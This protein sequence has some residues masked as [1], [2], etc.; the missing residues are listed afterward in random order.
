VPYAVDASTSVGSTD[1]G[2]IRGAASPHAIT[3]STT[4]GSITI[5]PAP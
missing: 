3:A 1:V 5:E 2:V 4:T